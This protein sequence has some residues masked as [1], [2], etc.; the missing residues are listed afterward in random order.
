MSD[1]TTTTANTPQN[2]RPSITTGARVIVNH[3]RSTRYGQSGTVTSLGVWPGDWFVLFDEDP[4]IGSFH[5]NHLQVID[6]AP[7][8]PAPAD[9]LG[10]T[11]ALATFEATF[12]STRRLF[13]GL[14]HEI[15]FVVPEDVIGALDNLEINTVYTIT[16]TRKQVAP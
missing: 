14:N 8:A 5:E 1:N 16:I 3:P 9:A 13:Y 4:A 11:L 7:P 12:W 2:T 6:A 10:D 15:V